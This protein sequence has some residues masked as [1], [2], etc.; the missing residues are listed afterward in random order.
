MGRRT[1]I[2]WLKGSKLDMLSIV[3]DVT[4]AKFKETL[5]LAL[6]EQDKMT[7]H[8]CAEAVSKQAQGVEGCDNVINRCHAAVMNCRVAVIDVPKEEIK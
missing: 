6:I 4:V 5:R 2:E 1:A 7:R 8:A 3:S